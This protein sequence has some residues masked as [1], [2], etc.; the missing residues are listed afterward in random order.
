MTSD[1]PEDGVPV[2]E[3]FTPDAA[4]ELAEQDRN[5]QVVGARTATLVRRGRQQPTSAAWRN[6]PLV[7][8]TIVFAALAGWYRQ[9]KVNIGYCGV[10]EPNWSLAS[11]P[12]IPA[13]VHEN[14]QPVCEP[15]PQHAACYPNMEVQCD[16]DFV[17][18]P[19]PLSLNG[20]MPLSPTCEPDSEKE[21]RIK[22]V[23]DRAVEELRERRAAYECGDEVASS[24]SPVSAATG[25]VKTI[26]K[27]A[28]SKLEIE[29]TELKK[30]VSK[31]RRKGMTET[32]FEELWQ[33]AL[34]DIIARDEVEVTH[35]G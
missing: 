34:G 9:E 5:G 18:K 4:R 2:T 25:E 30:T 17:L 35:D 16:K 12:H 19:H 29:E 28:P 26:A 13:W 1:E 3:E 33:G 14:F 21:R 23:A 27:A 7:I 24:A 31:L 11:N 32:E 10:G 6:A 15:C 22:A 20:L 8:I